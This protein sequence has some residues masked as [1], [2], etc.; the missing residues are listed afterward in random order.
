MILPGPIGKI[1]AIC[2]G[3]VS[4]VLIFLTIMLGF[5]FGL[6]PGWSGFHTLIVAL[7]FV[8]NVHLGIFLFT[9]G[10]AKSLCFA[11]APVLYYIGQFVQGHLSG[12]LNILAAIPVVGITDFSNY[13][14]AGAI[15]I[16][17]IIGALLGLLMARSVIRFRRMLL[18]FEEGS[19]Q[20]KK[21]HS[22]RW[23]YIL[24]RVL[25]GK[26]TKD[27]KSLF[28]GKT[29]IIRKAG[30]AIAVLI[31]AMSAGAIFLTKGDVTRNYAA[32]TLTRANGAEVNI[33]SLDLSATTGAVSA[34]GIQVTDANEPQNNQ[35][36]IGKIAADASLYHLLLGKIIMESVEVSDV[37]FNQKRDTAGKVLDVGEKEPAAFDPCEY[38][39]TAAD[40]SKL[41]TYFKDAKALK[42]K[43]QKVRKW[44]PKS[45]EGQA[46][47]AQPEQAPQKYL[48]YLVARASVPPTP[49]VMA[50]QV[51]LDKV[52]T[53]SPLFGNSQILM[54]NI[55]DSAKTAG[56]PVTLEMK[57]LDTQASVQVTVDYSSGGGVPEV[58]GTFGGFDLSKM[59]SGLSG[60]R[61]LMFDSGSASGNFQGHVTSE[62]IDLTFDV[63]V[64]DMKAKAGEGGVLGLDSKTASEALAVLNS[65]STKIRIVGPVTDPRLVFD[66]KGLEGEFKDALVKAGKQKLADEIDKQISEQVDK[67]LGD[68]APSEIKD[69][70][71]K[72]KGLLKGL[73]GGKE[74]K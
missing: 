27:A 6:V 66:V 29:K 24:D 69:V 34:S 71:E 37:R 35:V 62:A 59:Q 16:G 39:V 47:E 43:L 30:V 31:L 8:L 2:R 20:F 52:Q 14:V 11:A 60:S 46:A 40:I 70:V 36:A 65:L 58:S 63:S 21:W 5:W 22:N 25:I 3:G 53:G 18:K 64:A 32:A 51:L 17:P 74:D 12:L 28:T 54:T 41:E 19:E 67:Q 10:I 38:K 44:L 4:P 33:G 23:V 55:S 57:S 15:V 45:E 7:V 50:K 72:S 9:A 49:R 73:L 48:D 13:S 56:L 42:E 1:L 61:G 68:K 26:R